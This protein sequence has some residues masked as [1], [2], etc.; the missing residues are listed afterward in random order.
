MPDYTCKVTNNNFSVNFRGSARVRGF[1]VTSLDDDG[2]HYGC[3]PHRFDRVVFKDGKWAEKV[4]KTVLT[5]DAE[6]AFTEALME[7]MKEWQSK[8]TEKRRLIKKESESKEFDV[9]KHFIGIIHEFHDKAE[10]GP[11]KKD[12][13]V[14]L[15]LLK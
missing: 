6:E 5:K 3:I 14:L 7:V 9:I 10:D 11:M 4:I 15:W 12:L 13:E 8:E 1:S 2:R